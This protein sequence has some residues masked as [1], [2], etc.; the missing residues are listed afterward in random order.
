VSAR[1]NERQRALTGAS[2]VKEI[3]P[4]ITAMLAA[5]P[6]EVQDASWAAITEAIREQAGDAGAVRLTNMVLMAA[7]RA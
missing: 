3:A 2:F 6:E 4:P 5:H 1:Q 7:G